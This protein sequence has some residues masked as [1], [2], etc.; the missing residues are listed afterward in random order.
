MLSVT[1][2][3]LPQSPGRRHQQLQRRCRRE[4]VAGGTRMAGEGEDSKEDLELRQEQWKNTERA[5]V[6]KRRK[7]VGEGGERERETRTLARIQRC[8][9]PAAEACSSR[10]PLS[11][12]RKGRHYMRQCRTP[13]P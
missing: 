10:R 6:R 13:A 2:A 4:H 8:L 7:G 5:C 1:C 12:M 3:C 9:G 11:R